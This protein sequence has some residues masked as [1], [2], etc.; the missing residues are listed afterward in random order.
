MGFDILNRVF[1]RSVDQFPRSPLNRGNCNDA[2]NHIAGVFMNAGPTDKL[3]LSSPD[4]NMKYACLF[5]NS[6]TGRTERSLFKDIYYHSKT[7]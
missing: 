5:L 1:I 7:I 2:V 6:W 4:L 3:R